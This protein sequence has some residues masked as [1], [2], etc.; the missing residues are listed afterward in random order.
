MIHKY[1]YNK[2]FNTGITNLQESSNWPDHHTE[3]LAWLQALSRLCGHFEKR[4]IG[5][6]ATR[7]Q[8]ILN[9]TDSLKVLKVL[10]FNGIIT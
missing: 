7:K 2:D 5:N 10:N 6:S 9:V 8:N 1:F 4:K 3:K